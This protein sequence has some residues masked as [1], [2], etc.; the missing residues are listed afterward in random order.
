MSNTIS[1]EPLEPR[2]LI[3]KMSRDAEVAI[4]G[5]AVLVIAGI[6]IAIW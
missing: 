2:G 1:Y 5:I 6:C 3:P 4:V